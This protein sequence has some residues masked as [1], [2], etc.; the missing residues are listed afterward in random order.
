MHPLNNTPAAL[1][2]VNM[3]SHT[4]PVD[5][6]GNQVIMLRSAGIFT[7][8]TDLYDETTNHHT[9]D[10]EEWLCP[11]TMSVLMSVLFV[12]SLEGIYQH[13]ANILAR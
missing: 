10:I 11:A 8:N 4:N 9:A 2:N 1:G 5:F 6:A 13:I 3:R 12:R 7:P